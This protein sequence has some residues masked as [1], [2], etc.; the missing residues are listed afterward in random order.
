MTYQLN[1]YIQR[2]RPVFEDFYSRITSA[3][4]PSFL[5]TTFSA[6]LTNLRVLLLQACDCS[7]HAN[8]R[9]LTSASSDS[10]NAL[11]CA[12]TFSHNFPTCDSRLRLLTLRA[13]EPGDFAELILL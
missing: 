1:T 5:M 6:S 9:V 10:K 2:G 13:P 7:Y 4:S 8:R 3:K 11:I 12:H